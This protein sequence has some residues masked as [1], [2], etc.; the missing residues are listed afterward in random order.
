MPI[1]D[2]F[3]ERG[4]G[5]LGSRYPIMCGAMTWISDP[6]SVKE[7]KPLKTIIEE[8]VVEAETEMRRLERVFSEA[9]CRN[10]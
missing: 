6:G 10:L 5:F 1:I 4:R 9:I 8:M 2:R 7:I 3:F